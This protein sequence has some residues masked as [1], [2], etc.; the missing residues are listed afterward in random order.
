MNDLT[1]AAMYPFGWHRK[2]IEAETDFT[3]LED[4]ERW[5]DMLSLHG[6]KANVE[7][8][9]TLEDGRSIRL[10]RREGK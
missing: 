1:R 7:N 6:P 3:K 9:Y 8:R 4:C 10:I 5:A 2:Q